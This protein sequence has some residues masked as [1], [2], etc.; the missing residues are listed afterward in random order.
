MKKPFCARCKF[1]AAGVLVT[2]LIFVS[3]ASFP[4]EEPARH[5]VCDPPVGINVGLP[6]ERVAWQKH[7][8]ANGEEHIF[9]VGFFDQGIEIFTTIFAFKYGPIKKF[10]YYSFLN[11]D[12]TGKKWFIKGECKS[13]YRDVSKTS[14]DINCGNTSFSGKWPEWKLVINEKEFQAELTYRA[15]VPTFDVGRC[16]YTPDRKIHL[17]CFVFV[18]RGRVWGTVTTDGKVRKV[19]GQA[20]GDH[21]HQNL[22]P[23]RQGPFYY[24]VRVFPDPKT[25][26][27]EKLHLNFSNQALH[28]AYGGGADKFSFVVSDREVIGFTRNIDIKPLEVFEDPETGYK[29]VRRVKITAMGENFTVNGLF[30][31]DDVIEIFDIY[32]WLPPWARKI[33]EKFWKRPVYFRFL[34]KFNGVLD[35]DGNTVRIKQ[36]A[37]SEMN[38][39]Q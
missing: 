36:R 37:T 23:T 39:T 26:D 12:S 17:D 13:D 32:Q 3:N 9:L 27:D 15:T 35:I 11:E 29:Y 22:P 19:S 25:P 5:P 1:I 38:F 30:A 24:A 21:S 8:G 18:P 20:Y 14:L 28:K 2:T 4:G 6:S 33:A 16:F 34:G 10:G 31:V 7:A